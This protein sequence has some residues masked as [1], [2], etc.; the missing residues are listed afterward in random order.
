M[1]DKLISAEALKAHF[2]W[3]RDDEYKRIFT[4]II[5]AQK[6]AVVRCKD[7][8]WWHT[9]ELDK[10]VAYNAFWVTDPNDFC[11]WGERRE[12]GAHSAN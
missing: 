4:D 10:C 2:A 5:D 3:W 1:A 11:V 7:C 8:K 9:T 6:E 12:D